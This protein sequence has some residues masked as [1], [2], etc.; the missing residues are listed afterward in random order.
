MAIPLL[1]P[2]AR[3]TISRWLGYLFALGLTAI[4]ALGLLPGLQGSSH[5]A[6]A[7]RLPAEPLVVDMRLANIY[8]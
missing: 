3:P 5:A 1:P 7:P 2:L 6:P 8:G 4:L